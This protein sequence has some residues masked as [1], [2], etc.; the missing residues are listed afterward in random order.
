MLAT[1]PLGAT[2]EDSSQP[3]NQKYLNAFH[4][5]DKDPNNELIVVE[6][7]GKVIGVL[8]LTF[9]PYLSYIG[10]WRCLIEGVRIDKNYRGRGW[11]EKLF[12]YAIDK[13]QNKG[14]KLIQLSSDKGR[15]E[16]I[17]FYEKLGFVATHEGLKLHL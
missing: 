10:S 16:A 9:I 17:R 3:L 1:D 12:K 7:S 4:E 15:P 14:C 8:Q 5:I 11:G 13:A 6:H 2:R